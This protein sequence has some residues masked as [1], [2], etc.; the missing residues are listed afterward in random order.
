MNAAQPPSPAS[1]L[2]PPLWLLAEVTYRCPLHCAFCYNPVDFARDDTELSTEDWLRVLREARA[3]GSVQCGF[4][5][6]EPLMR[7]DLEVLVAEAHRLGYYTNLLTSG[8]GLTAERAQALKAAGL[9]HIQLSFQDS[10]RELNDFLSHTRTFDLKQRV[11][12]IIKDN[13]WPMVMNCVIHR[14]NIDYIDRIIEMAVELGAEYL[15]L[16]NSQYYSWALLNRDQLMPSREQLERAERITNEY[17]ERLGDRIRIFF[18][19]PDYYEKRPKKCMNG[20]GNVFLTVTPDGTALPCH[21]ARMLPGLEFP[22]VRDMDVK[23]IWY[24]SEGFN[25]YRGDSWMKDPCRT[26]PDKEKDHG[27]CRCQAYM[28]AGDP[29]A[30]DPVCDKSPDHHKVVEAVERANTPGWKGAE[31]P[32]IFR[33]PARSRELAACG[34]R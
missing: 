3:A 5:G 9:D 25:R 34:K 19:V 22:N 13:G 27:G 32:L 18:V 30:A 10:T 24:D 23:S 11:A 28:L 15:E 4:S 6:G 31:Q 26:C 17:R 12:G 8:V 33:D 20:W 16:A 14:L 29:A 7:D 21:T 1:T 2:G